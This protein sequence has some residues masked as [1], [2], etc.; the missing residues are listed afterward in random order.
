MSGNPLDYPSGE[1]EDVLGTKVPEPTSVEGGFRWGL[2][3]IK[4]VKVEL[5]R[6]EERALSRHDKEL[7]DR[8][9]ISKLRAAEVEQELLDKITGGN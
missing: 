2:S 3:H 8:I 9:T 6:L 5:L 7:L 1:I 4:Y